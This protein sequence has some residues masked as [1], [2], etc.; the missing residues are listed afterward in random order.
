MKDIH[1]KDLPTF[2]QT[3]NPNNDIFNLSMELAKSASK[4]STFGLY[5]FDALKQDVLDA[6]SPKFPNIYTISPL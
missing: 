5:T 2:F 6:L 1:P 3:T 4:A